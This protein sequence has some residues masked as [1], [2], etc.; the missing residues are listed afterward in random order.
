[1]QTRRCRNGYHEYDVKY[2]QC[3]ECQRASK[4]KNM[5]IWYALNKE[6]QSAD[7]KVYYRKHKDRIKENERRREL[8]RKFNLTVDEY[9]KMSEAQNNCCAICNQPEKLKRKLAVDHCH[10]TGT[11]RGLLCFRCNVAIGKLNDDTEL[12][13][14]AVTYLERF[15]K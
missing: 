4:A 14:K 7:K 13:K 5:P 10:K 1:M 3:P 15:K 9:I 11:V 6:K 8:K 12:I 2:K